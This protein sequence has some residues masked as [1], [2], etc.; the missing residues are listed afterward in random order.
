M[1][2]EVLEGD[3]TGGEKLYIYTHQKFVITYN[4][5][6]VMTLFR[7]FFSLVYV[8]LTNSLGY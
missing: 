8:M 2:G 1:V 3:A 6:R 5:N 4:D 7:T